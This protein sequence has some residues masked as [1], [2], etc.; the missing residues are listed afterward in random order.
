M[1]EPYASEH[2]L[3][4]CRLAEAAAFAVYLKDP[5]DENHDRWM[6]AQQ[7][8]EAEKRALRGTEAPP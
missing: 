8:Y 4:D 7:A 6:R 1:T 2:S 3:Q 5:S